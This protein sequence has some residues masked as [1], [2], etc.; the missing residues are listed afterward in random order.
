MKT[1]HIF[2]MGFTQTLGSNS[3]QISL[4]L[5]ARAMG[6]LNH[7]ILTPMQWRTDPKEIANFLKLLSS[8]NT[9]I[10][11][12]FYS[13]GAGW[14]FRRLV[15]EMRSLGIGFESVVLCDPVV[16]SS[17]LPQWLPINPT[18]LM[19]WPTLSIPDNVKEVYVFRQKVDKPR[20]HRVVAANPVRTRLVS[21]VELS[22]KHSDM[23]DQPE[24]HDLVL[25]IIEEITK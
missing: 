22:V 8:D 2:G 13:W 12:Y 24:Y 11:G 10:F 19:S 17:V 21:D 25:S 23:E 1:V 7:C 6:S 4:W 5:K 15:K 9:K 3:G 16:R 18:S 20:A 14:F